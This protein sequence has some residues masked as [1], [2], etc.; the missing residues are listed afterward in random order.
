MIKLVHIRQEDGITERDAFVFYNSDEGCF[1]KFYGLQVWE[2]WDEFEHAF[3]HHIQPAGPRNLLP[4]LDQFKMVFQDEWEK[5][6]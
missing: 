2:T 6:I 5:R 3:R 1:Y 4:H